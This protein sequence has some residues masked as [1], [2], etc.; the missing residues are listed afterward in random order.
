MI[1]LYLLLLTPALLL[2][3]DWALDR[4]AGWR[5]DPRRAIDALARRDARR[6]ALR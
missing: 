6:E 2:V 3:A 1:G 5:N 4:L